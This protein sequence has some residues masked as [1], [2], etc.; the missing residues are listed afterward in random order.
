M[1]NIALIHYRILIVAILA[2]LIWIHSIPVWL[3][4]KQI[5][6]INFKALLIHAHLRSLVL[7]AII[8]KYQANFLN[9]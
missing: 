6:L 7:I 4:V 8:N 2:N 9:A 3:P 1:Y 5:I